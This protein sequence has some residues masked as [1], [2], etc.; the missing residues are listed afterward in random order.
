[1]NDSFDVK[2]TLDYA[3]LLDIRLTDL[4]V[5][6]LKYCVKLLIESKRIVLRLFL[7]LFVVV[8]LTDNMRSYERIKTFI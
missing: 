7:M 4:R 1:M 8:V 3:H 6:F 5:F 2:E